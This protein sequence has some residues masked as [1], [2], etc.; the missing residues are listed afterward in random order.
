[1]ISLYIFAKKLG[2]QLHIVL[3]MCLLIPAITDAAGLG[4]LKVKSYLG[5]TLDA[6]IEL[7]ETSADE[8]PSLTA[9]IA[10]NDEY[11]AAGLQDSVVP[12]GIKINAVQRADGVRILHLT[13]TRPIN[14][15]FLELLI[16]VNSETLHLVR[17]Y[18][19]LLDPPNSKLGDDGNP[20]P[21]STNQ[22]AVASRTYE[23]INPS[24]ASNV[25]APSAAQPAASAKARKRAAREESGGS[26]TS[27]SNKATEGS[28]VTEQLAEKPVKA[29]R[30]VQPIQPEPVETKSVVVAS[31]DAQT[32]LTQKGDIFG[33]VAQQYQPA[34]ISLKHVMAALY[35][36]NPDAFL[37]G[38]INQLKA[39]QVLRIPDIS[40]TQLTRADTDAHSNEVKPTAKNTSNIS[41]KPAD[42][43]AGYVLK[44]SP[45]DA[46]PKS[47][48][49][50]N[51][52]ARINQ[53]AP[54]AQSAISV[55][56]PP[57][58]AVP[59]ESA[60][61]EVP[62]PADPLT[63][64]PALSVATPQ[65]PVPAIAPVITPP[66]FTQ[67]LFSNLQWIFIGMLIPV[68]I[69]LLVFLLNKRRQAKMR[70]LQEGVFGSIQASKS[71][72]ENADT[73]FGQEVTST[74]ED[75]VNTQHESLPQ[76]VHPHDQTIIDIDE[77]DPLVEAEIYISYGRDE[78]A[79]SILTHALEST[80]ERHEL[81]YRLL[82]IYAG[83]HDLASFERYAKAVKEAAERG[84][85]E[86][87]VIWGK[88]AIL[89]S[90][91]DSENPLYDIEHMHSDAPDAE[92]ALPASNV[93]VQPD[94]SA[95]EDTDPFSEASI[96]TAETLEF[97]P[98]E[99]NTPPAK[100]FQQLAPTDQLPTIEQHIEAKDHLLE[101]TLPE[102]ELVVVKKSGK[103]STKK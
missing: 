34:G 3:F 96:A 29:K 23:M 21:T 43:N 79:E 16:S 58:A 40:G 22:P 103:T 81:S 25:I 18:T 98:L 76:A 102:P 31:G 80:P 37:D 90:Q 95:D 33:K 74:D 70:R 75:A 32:Y 47:D 62:P 36:A 20:L 59:V 101:F 1:M 87:V 94:I 54:N 63:P 5:E 4:K 60:I 66:S 48:E 13:S 44:I 93:V 56:Q 24:G 99:M 17:Q 27:G 65:V 89:G 39:G 28:Q 85:E 26:D 97:P 46:N 71:T 2:K 55:A 15:P 69:F 67:N 73:I 30:H 12:T 82:V 38:D 42:A 10:N 35:K 83:R 19:M 72:L 64:P 9:R 68:S 53:S 91:L 78:Q 84:A 92:P 7:V 57:V 77:I 49:Q 45:G 100:R 41:T 88:V 6:D 50:D 8:L 61:S 14:E 11:V 86:D 52:Q 51:N